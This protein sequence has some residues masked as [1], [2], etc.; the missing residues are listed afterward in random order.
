MR[1]RRREGGGKKKSAPYSAAFKTGTMGRKGG[2]QYGKTFKRG[3][4]KLRKS[5]FSKSAASTAMR[6]ALH[7]GAIKLGPR[8]TVKA[9]RAIR[10]VTSSY[11]KKKNK[12]FRASKRK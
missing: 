4:T 3:Y 2:G 10:A 12:A 1:A 11:W 6:N 5:G 9:E 7:S 8:S